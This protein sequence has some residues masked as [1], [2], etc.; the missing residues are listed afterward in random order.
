MGSFGLGHFLQKDGLVAAAWAGLNA[1]P[2]TPYFPKAS[3]F[4]IS[5][6]DL[7]FA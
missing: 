5:E 3:T 1:E 4:N 2:Y 7:N 6:I